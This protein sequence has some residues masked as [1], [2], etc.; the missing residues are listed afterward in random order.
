VHRP[1]RD[2]PRLLRQQAALAKFGSYAFR[3]PNLGNILTEAARVCAEGLEVAFCKVC[4]YRE[5][6]HDL[7]IEAGFGWHAGVVGLVVSQADETSP[8]GRAYVTGDPVIIRNLQEA[9][10]VRLPAFYPQHGIVSTVD[11]IIRRMDGEPYGVL[12]IDSTDEREYDQHDIDF[13]TGFANVLAEAVA[14]SQRNAVLRATTEQMLALIVEKDRLLDERAMMAREM[15]HRVR[16]SLHV[17]LDMLTTCL[18]QGSVD[19]VELDRIIHRVTALAEVHEQ[20]LGSDWGSTV[21]LG[22]YLKALCLRLPSLQT[23]ATRGIVLTCVTEPVSASVETAT[24]LG[25]VVAEL[26]SNSYRHAFLAAG[27]SITVTL[28]RS[29]T[30]DEMVLVI[31]DDGPGF[32]EKPGSKRFGIG[33]VRRLVQQVGGSARL[34]SDGGAVW[35]IHV[36]ALADAEYVHGTA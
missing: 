11:V 28:R 24:T 5:E 8:Q 23:T 15:N 33:L 29:G 9:N 4:R 25:M 2:V 34:R 18:G 27:G 30:A 3:E 31:A 12:E 14:T 10:N 20:L 7:L 19:G 26:V 17:I 36:P 1:E 22:D 21:H 6:E 35:T 16:N 13:L 32:V